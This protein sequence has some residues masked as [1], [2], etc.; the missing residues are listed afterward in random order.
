[1]ITSSWVVENEKS[2]FLVS[3]IKVFPTMPFLVLIVLLI[4]AAGKDMAEYRAIGWKVVYNSQTR[5]QLE[6]VTW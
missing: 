6:K 1:M 4:V 3:L 5:I 2:A